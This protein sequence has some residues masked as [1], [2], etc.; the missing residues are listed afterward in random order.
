VIVH[1][2]GYSESD[3]SHITARLRAIGMA[4]LGTYS[5]GIASA[6]IFRSQ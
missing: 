6:A 4:E 3:L 1:A 2:S 5:D